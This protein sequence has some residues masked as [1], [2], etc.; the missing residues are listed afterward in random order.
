MEVTSHDVEAHMTEGDL[1]Y[2]H[3]LQCSGVKAMHSDRNCKKTTNCWA[4]K[5]HKAAQ[6]SQAVCDTAVHCNNKQNSMKPT[7]LILIKTLVRKWI[8]SRKAMQRRKEEGRVLLLIKHFLYDIHTK[9]MQ[10]WQSGSG[11]TRLG[12]WDLSLISCWSRNDSCVVFASSSGSCDR[13]NDDETFKTLR[14]CLGVPPRPLERS[15]NSPESHAESHPSVHNTAHSVWC[16]QGSRKK[17]RKTWKSSRESFSFFFFGG[18]TQW[19]A[20]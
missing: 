11:S 6:W 13:I 20:P 8:Q 19:T 17:K 2:P 15:W 9:A 3:F 7:M 1:V 12:F 4:D 14:L 18:K 10:A 5:Q 16:V